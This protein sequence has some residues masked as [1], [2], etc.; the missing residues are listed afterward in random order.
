MAGDYVLS[1]EMTL[2]TSIATAVFCIV[3]SGWFAAKFGQGKAP[4]VEPGC[5]K[6]GAEAYA[7]QYQALERIINHIL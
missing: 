4:V 6:S 3:G 5:P 7:M 1:G 2:Y